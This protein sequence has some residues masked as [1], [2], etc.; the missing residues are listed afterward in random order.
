M[1]ALQSF[2]ASFPA[3]IKEPLTDGFTETVRHSAQGAVA[4]VLVGILLLLLGKRVAARW[5][6]LLWMLVVVRLAVPVTVRSPLSVHNLMPRPQNTTEVWRAQLTSVENPQALTGV[7]LSPA[8]V[9]E[10]IEAGVLDVTTAVA[11]KNPLEATPLLAPSPA[12]QPTQSQLSVLQILAL[13]WLVGIVVLLARIAYG[14]IRLSRLVR[15]MD[16]PDDPAFVDL[17]DQSAREMRVRSAPALL[18]SDELRMPALVGFWRPILL[19]PQAVLDTFDRRELRLIFLHELAHQR[20][21]DVLVNWVLALVGA[22]HWFNPVAWWA[23]SRVR[24]E[25]ELACDEMVLARGSEAE[26]GEMR[27]AYGT[28]MIKLLQSLSRSNVAPGAVGILEGRHLLKRR[29]AMI[30]SFDGRRRGTMLAAVAGLILGAVALTGPVRGEKAPEGEGG[31]EPAGAPAAPGQVAVDPATGA[32]ATSG[33]EAIIGGG[34]GIITN[35]AAAAAAMNP[36]GRGAEGGEAG[37][38]GGRRGGFPG[39]ELGQRWFME[40]PRAHAGPG[41]L[42]EAEATTATWEQLKKRVPELN[43][44]GVPLKDVID[45]LRDVT[46]VNIHVNWRVLEGEGIA[47]DAPVTLRAKNL[48]AWQALK[49]V[50]ADVSDELY[51]E[52]EGGLMTISAR[53]AGLRRDLVTKAYDVRDLLELGDLGKPD[54]SHNPRLQQATEEL[55]KEERSLATLTRQFGDANTKVIEARNRVEAMRNSVA[56]LRGELEGMAAP[57][58]AQDARQIQEEKIS[59]LVSILTST[60]A[61]DSWRE[62]GGSDGTILGFN[63]KL[64]VSTTEANHREIENVLKMIRGK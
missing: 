30:A 16:G 44:A 29:M 10:L 27:R 7:T 9:N 39:I 50:L 6:Y 56:V 15:R 19:M 12:A 57:N 37:R 35:N 58:Q 52:V 45:F 32:A 1:N 51:F 17:L 54:V 26:R 48:P 23:L 60:V 4:A 53:G 34:R 28:T 24:A 64:I 42:V 2:A 8:E 46:G 3:W 55:E 61:P 59:Q 13:L 5:R 36:R 47:G 40:S 11:D 31:A 22:V 43:F 14:T 63:T 49:M 20:R 33:G 25:R 21:G 62:M 41:A 18:V 38:Y